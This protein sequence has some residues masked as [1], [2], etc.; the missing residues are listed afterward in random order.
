MG[1]LANG[2]WSIPPDKESQEKTAFTVGNKHFVYERLPQGYMNSAVHFQATIMEILEG[3]PEEIY[4][5][6]I[7]LILDD[8][9][10]HVKVVKEVLNRIAEAGLKINI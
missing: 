1:D 7:I 10:E 8:E 4:V 6:H 3:L 9:E 5:D 2:F